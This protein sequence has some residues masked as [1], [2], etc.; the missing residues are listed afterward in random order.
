METL[1]TEYTGELKTKVVHIKSGQVIKTDAPID[2]KGRGEYFS[3]TDLIATSLT[4]CI[5]T[6]MGIVAD[7]HNFSIIGTTAKTTKIMLSDPRRI[8]E[9]II[10]INF[11]ANEYSEK[12]RKILENCVKN[13]P[14]ARSL[15]PDVK[16]TV[17]LNFVNH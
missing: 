9:I 13:C 11:P 10:E 7:N 1:F 6:V 15:H 3:P 16:Q 8:G 4:T 14:V 5:V 17:I 2:N 12:E